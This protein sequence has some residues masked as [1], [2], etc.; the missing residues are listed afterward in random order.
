MGLGQRGLP[1]RALEEAKQISR[2]RLEWPIIYLLQGPPVNCRGRLNVFRMEPRRGGKA[3][4]PFL[5]WPAVEKPVGLTASCFRHSHK[6]ARTLLASLDWRE[7]CVL[8]VPPI[9]MG[10]SHFLLQGHHHLPRSIITVFF[11]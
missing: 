6:E 7:P 3:L 10:K 2:E 4:G 5:Q 1:E 9:F 8:G 11:S